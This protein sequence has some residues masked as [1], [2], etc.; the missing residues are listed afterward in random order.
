MDTVI[1]YC[2]ATGSDWAL[3]FDGYAWRQRHLGSFGAALARRALD[4][5]AGQ[6][7]EFRLL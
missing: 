5:P 6:P 3:T 7:V 2:R 4:L 1:I